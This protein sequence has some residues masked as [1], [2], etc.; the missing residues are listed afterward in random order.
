MLIVT[1]SK[2]FSGRGEGP[3]LLTLPGD[4]GR[5]PLDP[6]RPDDPPSGGRGDGGG[7]GLV[8]EVLAVSGGSEGVVIGLLS[9]LEL[10][11]ELI[12]LG[13]GHF[14]FLDGPGGDGSFKRTL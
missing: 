3:P 2:F 14:N 1:S 11:L 8:V 12:G 6:D 4:G 9:E 7:G 10:G 13:D 5:S